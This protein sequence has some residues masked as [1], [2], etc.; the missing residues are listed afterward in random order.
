VT[1]RVDVPAAA[2]NFVAVRIGV[3]TIFFVAVRVAGRFVGVAASTVSVRVVAN[4]TTK[5]RS[6]VAHTFA[7]FFRYFSIPSPYDDHEMHIV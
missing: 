2:A 5:T 6:P 3:A 7:K 1:T 4:T